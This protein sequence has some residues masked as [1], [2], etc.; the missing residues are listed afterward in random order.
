MLAAVWM[1][2]RV[3]LVRAALLLF[4]VQLIVMPGVWAYYF[5]WPVALGAIFPSVGYLVYTL[6]V[7]AF[8]FKSPDVVGLDWPRLPGWWGC[9]WATC[10]GSSR[11]VRALR[12]SRPDGAPAQP[13]YEPPSSI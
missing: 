3:E 8:F 9:W 6:T 2:R 5:V 11:E 10:S 7:A 13:G 4:L 12:S 1:L